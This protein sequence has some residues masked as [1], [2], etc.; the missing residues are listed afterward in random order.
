MLRGIRS[1]TWLLRINCREVFGIRRAYKHRL[2]EKTLC[3]FL[4][5]FQVVEQ[6]KLL[7]K[8]LKI[9]NKGILCKALISQTLA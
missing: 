8:L 7:G 2:R 6:E 3:L 1:P 9:L 4:T 5:D